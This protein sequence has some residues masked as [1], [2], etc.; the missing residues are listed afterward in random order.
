MIEWQVLFNSATNIAIFLLVFI[1]FGYS[2]IMLNK[3]QQDKSIGYRTFF[4]SL[5]LLVSMSILGLLI[6]PSYH[7]VLAEKTTLYIAN[8]KQLPSELR[9]HEY[10]YIKN[11]IA[12]DTSY[13][14]RN[15]D[16]IVYQPE[17]VVLKKPEVTHL[18]LVGEGLLPSQL[19]LFQ[20][21]KLS[22]QP[23]QKITGI[24]QPIW[25][26]RLVLGDQLEFGAFFQSNNQS[27]YQVQL[28]NPARQVE[29]EVSVI[30]G[31]SFVLNAHPKI[32]GTHLY[33]LIVSDNSQ[34]I[35]RELSIPVEVKDPRIAK[36]LIIQSAPSFES[37]QIQNWAGSYGAELLI[38]TRISKEKFMTRATN[39]SQEVRSRPEY[40]LD[41]NVLSKFDILIIDARE[42]LFFDSKQLNLL[43]EM[44]RD[45]LGVLI[46]AD[47]SLN[48]KEN[49]QLSKLISEFDVKPIKENIRVDLIA[50]N[51]S[52]NN[53]IFADSVLL[54]AEPLFN[55]QQPVKNLLPL[56]LNQQGHVVVAQKSHGLGKITLSVIKHSYQLRTSDQAKAYSHFWSHIIEHTARPY[57]ETDLQ[58]DSQHDLLLQSHRTN[59][60]IEFRSEIE[61]K[62]PEIATE[63]N[64]SG[65][66]QKIEVTSLNRLKQRTSQ[67]IDLHATSINPRKLCGQFWPQT[68]GW[69][70][71][72]R[73][74]I[75]DYFYVHSSREWLA[76][77]QNTSLNAT[78]SRIATWNPTTTK[79]SNLNTINDWYYWLLIVFCSGLIWIERKFWSNR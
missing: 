70:K 39:L 74:G 54:S 73:A 60:C 67:N 20:N 78:E 36:I 29:D 14:A 66:G 58:I 55:I 31:D 3:R 12:I 32:T 4:V 43:D 68:T 69:H 61:N 75:E 63:K 13:L 76:S 17:Q 5:N 11:D 33:Q 2:M 34:N 24:I 16:K 62:T 23:S 71:I 40:L 53:D 77:Q 10:L 48:S 30:N 64:Y 72:S 7:A 44:T 45:G 51:Q 41:K 49:T 27:I 6:Q 37:K 1:A 46:R 52:D 59:I 56:V 79:D 65:K 57:K 26:T 28:I 15:R 25:N 9:S 38:R 50:H 47:G 8:E 22:I 35:I 21:L 18:M 42:L 19:L